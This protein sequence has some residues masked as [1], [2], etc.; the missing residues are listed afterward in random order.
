MKGEA[1]R[2]RDG[3]ERG[4]RKKGRKNQKK[5]RKEGRIRRRKEQKDEA[6][7]NLPSRT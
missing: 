7:T 1:V 2:A 4:R 3:T 6:E 5:E